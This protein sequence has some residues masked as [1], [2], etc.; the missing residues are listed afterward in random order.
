MRE[1]ELEIKS[2]T[3]PTM[4]VR[5]Q[6]IVFIKRNVE[7]SFAEEIENSIK[8]GKHLIIIITD[9]EP[10]KDILNLI[11]G[12]PQVVIIRVEH[13]DLIKLLTIGLAKRERVE[14]DDSL[15]LETYEDLVIKTGLRKA[16]EEEWEKK[17]SNR[18]YIITCRGF[19]DRLP[20]ACKF[21]INTL[22]KKMGIDD[23]IDYN[24]KLR[25][26]LPFGVQTEIIPD[27]DK[28]ELGKLIK[29]L[30]DFKFLK[31]D[32]GKFYL[33]RHPIEERIITI[34]K[35]FGGEAQK[36]EIMKFFVYTDSEVRV[37]E[38]IF[39][40]MRRKL[41]IRLVGD[42]IQ[43][44]KS[45]E[46]K[47]MKESCE[48]GF[49]KYKELINR[50]HVISS[51]RYIIT[52]KKRERHFISLDDLEENIKELID[53]VNTIGKNIKNNEYE[54]EILRSRVFLIFQLVEWYK[55]YV[56]KIKLAISEIESKTDALENKIKDVEEKT[57]SLLQRVRKFGK[58]P[59]EIQI[60][61]LEKIR[62][63]L[64]EVREFLA[65]NESDKNQF[66]KIRDKVEKIAG[67]YKSVDK[68]LDEI[69]TT[70]IDKRFAQEYNVK[71]EWTIV[72]YLL[73]TKKLEEF[74]KLGEFEKKLEE[75]EKNIKQIEDELNELDLIWDKLKNNQQLGNFRLSF[76]STTKI[77][78][79]IES[80]KD[81]YLLVP[82]V[83]MIEITEFIDTIEKNRK[84]IE[85]E[86]DIIK[87]LIDIIEKL[88]E[89]EKNLING[90]KLIDFL[91][92]VCKKINYLSE[93]T[94]DKNEILKKYNE[95][96]E[97]YN[98]LYFSNLEEM[99]NSYKNL[100]GE[101]ASLGEKTRKNIENYKN[102]INNVILKLEEKQKN[103]KNFGEKVLSKLIMSEPEKNEIKKVLD[104]LSNLF[105]EPVV[106]LKII[107]EKIDK[108]FDYKVN[109]SWNTENI[110]ERELFLISSLAYKIKILNEGEME[111]FLKIME[112]EEKEDKEWVP[113]DD[114]VIKVS[115]E[116]NKDS[117][118]VK[119]IISN[120]IK[121]GLLISGVK[122]F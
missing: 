121:R 96:I 78:S 102:I 92:E 63:V 49:E 44:I 89:E 118:D 71:G 20:Q 75:F 77:L 9:K 56:N 110:I 54:D 99:K 15:L 4:K 80:K 73:F 86:L 106:Q 120:L 85:K 98:K 55:I 41:L 111:V 45:D 93:T 114:L 68:S 16:I 51:P 17:M 69:F 115:K 90:L 116:L 60:S 11:E 64:N 72:K 88:I 58:I 3:N 34:L 6:T 10:P 82:N 76:D 83:K 37:L 57:Y 53:E 19:V 35:D 43:L 48:D 122:V 97:R 109:I 113:L 7:F 52:W 84:R 42:K 29:E 117:E 107:I 5:I 18:G 100:L 105:E 59:E 13:R 47:K 87:E 28:G 70:D 61:E 103:I 30:K 27:M 12:Y 67:S 91:S 39:S 81:E 38:S 2:P 101:I 95:T 31:E 40:H 104:M 65:I 22:G 119:N 1:F 24:W 50:N 79:L 26:L 94:S 32:E 36:K 112:I 33:C 23:I 25:K 66:E 46:V 14:I 108:D 8:R 62:N 21:F 74:S